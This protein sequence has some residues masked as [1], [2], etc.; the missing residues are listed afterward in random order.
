[1]AETKQIVFTHREVAEAFIRYHGIHEGLW[2]LYVEFGLA[3]ANINTT[4]PPNADIVP[5]AIVP[6]LKLGIQRFDTPNSLTAD[7]A[8]V[9]PVRKRAPKKR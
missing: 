8:K 2:G 6:I 9:N 1:M 4:P 7:A 5:A 3:A